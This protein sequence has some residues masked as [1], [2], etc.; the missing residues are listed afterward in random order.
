MLTHV[1]IML[2]LLQISLNGNICYIVLTGKFG[3]FAPDLRTAT[4][5]RSHAVTS[6]LI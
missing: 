3:R 1:L 2:C 6:V 5:F 4:D